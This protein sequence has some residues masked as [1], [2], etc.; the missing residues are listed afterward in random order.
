MP[1]FSSDLQ[2]LAEAA[3]GL[4][5]LAYLD[6]IRQGRLPPPP[7]AKLIGFTFTQVAD[8]L[9]AASLLPRA[10]HY[11]AIGTVHGGIIA[12]ILDTVMG[13]AVHSRLPQGY[14]YTTLEIK[15]NYVRGVTTAVGELSAAAN[16]VHLGK[17][18][19]TAEGQV[20]DIAGKLYAHG[21]TTCLVFKLP[22]KSE[23]GSAAAAQPSC[24][25]P[26]T[27]D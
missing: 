24:P 18:I 16:T 2:Q 4:S 25:Q 15:I 9:V 21:T 20:R 17:Q 23:S 12:T 27:T 26:V 8:G 10:E 22:E 5:G 11:N 14:A 6:A 19:A 13:C 1:S 7:V 3:R